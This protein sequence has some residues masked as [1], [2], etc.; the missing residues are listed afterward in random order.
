MMKVNGTL[1]LLSFF[2]TSLI[3]PLVKAG[4]GTLYENTIIGQEEP[5]ARMD[6]APISW[7]NQLIHILEIFLSSL[8]EAYRPYIN[9][10]ELILVNPLF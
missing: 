5:I 1:F 9:D 3:S 7:I 8:I 2:S 4:D 10:P 6:I